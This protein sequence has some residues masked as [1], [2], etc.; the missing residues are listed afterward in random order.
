MNRVVFTIGV[1]CLANLIRSGVIVDNSFL[2]RVLLL[3]LLLLIAIL[4]GL[5]NKLALRRNVFEISFVLFYAWNLLSCLWATSFP[6][7]I[8][9]AQLVFLGFAVFLIVSAYLRKNDGFEGLFIKVQLIVLVFS[10]GLVLFKLATIEFFDPYK[11]RSIS[12]NNNLYSGFLL[13]SLPLI[14][15]GYSIHRGFW[16]YLSAVVAVGCLFSIIIIQ[17]RAVYLGVFAAGLI[18]FSFILFRY[19]SVFTKRNIL[20]GMASFVLLSILVAVFYLSLDQTRRS[21][22]LSKIPVWQYIGSYE[23]PDADRL[24]RKLETEKD[25]LSGI[26][27]FDFS[28]DF[29]ET[30]NLRIIFWKKSR[31]LIAGHPLLGVGAGSWRLTIPSCSTPPNPDHTEKNYTY[32]QPHNEWISTFAELGIVGLIL[33]L[34]LLIVPVGILFYRLARSAPKPDISVL[35]YA[36]FIVGFYLFAVFDFP[37]K[38][39][40]HNVLLFSIFAFLLNKSPLNSQAPLFSTITARNLFSWTLI[41]LLLFTVFVAAARIKGEYFT[42]RMFRNERKNDI[43]VIRYCKQAENAFYRITPNTLPLAW[44]EGVAWHRLGDVPKAAGCF[45]RALQSTPYEVRVLNDYGISL[46]ALQETK[47]AKVVLLQS[48]EI[49]PY[50]DDAK[51]NL[52]AIYYLARQRD[53]ALIYLSRC[54]DSQ[55]KRDFLEEM[56]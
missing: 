15:T 55:K 42:L 53:S 34:F 33:F 26:A 47:E 40:E 7:A 20:V 11:I 37:L 36:S 29:Y 43:Q 12:A 41:L 44:F 21:Y 16:K 14:L 49:D 32:S 23:N 17:S 3:S 9:Q 19:R 39:V 28:E 52:A 10:F 6:E 4:T 38:R 2:P 8:I 31:C 45:R 46:Y 48:L 56:K 54:T 35:F 25:N 13:I 50:F 22:F 24:R 27:P 18:T 51:L 1:L 5:R 30:A